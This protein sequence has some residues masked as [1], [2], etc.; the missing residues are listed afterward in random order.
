PL[1]GWRGI[2]RLFFVAGLAGNLAEMLFEHGA[3]FPVVGA[4]GAISAFIVYYCQRYPKAR[5]RL[6]GDPESD[7]L[8]VARLHMSSDAVLFLCI[9]LNLYGALRSGIDPIPIAYFSPL[10]GILVGLIAFALT[11]APKSE[12]DKAQSPAKGS[13]AASP[14]ILRLRR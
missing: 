7:L 9:G 4:S 2:L 6:P 3:Y 13:S 11:P 8:W 14:A 12:P 1:M 10:G 5:F